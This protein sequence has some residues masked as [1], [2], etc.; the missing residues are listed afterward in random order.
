M[1]IAFIKRKDIIDR[2]LDKILNGYKLTDDDIE[3]LNDMSN[4]S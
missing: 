3:F 1:E 2:Y 4:E